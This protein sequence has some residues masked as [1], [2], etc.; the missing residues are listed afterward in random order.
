MNIVTRSG[1][2][3][4]PRHLFEFIRERSHERAQFLCTGTGHAEAQPVRWRAGGPIVKNKLFFFGTYQGTRLRSTAAGRVAFVPDCGRAPRRLLFR[5]PRSS[6]IR[7]T[8]QPFP[9]TRFRRSGSTRCP[10]YFPELDPAAERRRPAADLPGT[11]QSD[12]EPVHAEDRLQPLT[13]APVQRPVLLHRFRP[14]GG[15]PTEQCPRG[16]NAGNAVRVQNV[17]V[18]HTYTTSSDSSF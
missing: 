18:N 8:R 7:V 2:N 12:R 14:S 6:S 1:T 17:S 11:Q 5:F 9:G 4:I 16:R 13:A 10:R 15:D 3:E